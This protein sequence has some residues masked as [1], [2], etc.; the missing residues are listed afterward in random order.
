MSPSEFDTIGPWSEVKLEILREY[1]EPY[2]RI[3]SGKG[4]YHLYIDGFAGRGLHLSRETGQVI[5]GSPLNA[6]STNPP[7]REYHLIDLDAEKVKQLRSH[8]GSRPD[9]HIYS[10]D[11]NQILLTEVFPQARYS[12]YRRALCL[13]D[14]FN[15]GLSWEVVQTA[16]KMRS[17]EIFL[18][19]MV[20]DM[21]MNVLLTRP[22]SAKPDQL[23]RMTGFWGDE[24]W[25][26]VVY[27]TARQGNFLT[28]RER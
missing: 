1:A 24:S 18:N 26:D 9:V 28:H 25:R 7:F 13:L 16:G 14:P 5:Q 20:M 22:E 21:N 8:V 27:E 15:I 23:G 19:F 12:D 6:L 4:F 2:S 11:C 3:V 10:G 17:I